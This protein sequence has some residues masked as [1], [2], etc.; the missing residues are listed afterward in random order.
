MTHEKRD[1]NPDAEKP[2]GASRREGRGRALASVGPTGARSVEAGEAADRSASD[3]VRVS[4][5]RRL[6]MV[7]SRLL[8]GRTV[9]VDALM[10]EFEIHRRTVLRD[11]SELREAGLN[12]VY[13]PE[14]GDHRIARQWERTG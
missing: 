10:E 5:I 12:I 3:T 2:L 4:R 11:L 13:A 8:S 6:V 1:L 14:S 7:A 9:R